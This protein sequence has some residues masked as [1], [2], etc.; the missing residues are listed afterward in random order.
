MA[1][2]AGFKPKVLKLRKGD[3]THLVLKSGDGEEHC[4]AVDELRIEKRIRAGK[5]TRPRRDARARRELRFLRLSRARK[6][7]AA[8]QARRRGVASERQAVWRRHRA[9]RGARVF[10]RAAPLSPAPRDPLRVRCPRRSPSLD[11]H[12]SSNHRRLHRARQHLRAAHPRRSRHGAATWPRE[13]LVQPGSPDLGLRSPG[14]AS[15]S[16]AASRSKRRTPCSRPSASFARASLERRPTT[17]ATSPA[18]KRSGPTPSGF[19]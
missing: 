9:R 5:P 6:R 4:F 10:R 18:P 13:E 19:T 11:P 2:K 7:S 16:T 14:P 1:T 12:F 8:R 15:A 17:S 3:T